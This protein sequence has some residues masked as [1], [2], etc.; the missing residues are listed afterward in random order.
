MSKKSTPTLYKLQSLMAA[1][2]MRPLNKDN[3]QT[4]WVDGSPTSD[5][6]SEF[7]KPNKKLT[8][9]ER[10]EIYNK[11]YWYRLLDSLQED[12]PGVNALLGHT[13]FALFLFH[14]WIH[15]Q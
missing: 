4:T 8:S 9:F 7:I 14:K 1:A 11:Q 13:R 12:F 10:L 15:Q 5:Y 3:M 6:V 2:I